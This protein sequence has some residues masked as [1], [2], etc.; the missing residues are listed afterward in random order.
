MKYV[1][2]TYAGGYACIEATLAVI[3][4]AERIG[5]TAISSSDCDGINEEDIID[6]DG[7][8]L[9]LDELVESGA[10]LRIPVSSR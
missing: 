5:A 1:R 2:N 10:A 8:D 9:Y 4:Y 7:Y 6:V 3:A